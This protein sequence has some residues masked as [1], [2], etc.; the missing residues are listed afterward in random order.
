MTKEYVFDFSMTFTADPKDRF[1]VTIN[2][3]NAV[4]KF[5]NCSVHNTRVYEVMSIGFDYERYVKTDAKTGQVLHEHK[6]ENWV[7]Q[8]R[9]EPPKQEPPRPSPPPQSPPPVEPA[10][11]KLLGSPRTLKDA[12]KA[13]R[14]L[15][16]ECHPDIG[17]SHDKMVALNQAMEQARKWLK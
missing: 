11:S 9:Q 15:T 10:W 6:S 17:G 5:F 8:T 13:Y 1:N 3:P 12:E 16:R 7:E 4:F 14:K 2:M